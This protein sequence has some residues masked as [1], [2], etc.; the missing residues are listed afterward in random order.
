MFINSS[1]KATTLVIIIGLITLYSSSLTFARQIPRD[2][3]LTDNEAEIRLGFN[4]NE[5]ERF[6]R[7]DVEYEQ[8]LKEH[9]S[10]EHSDDRFY[11]CDQCDKVLERKM[12][13]SNHIRIH[14]SNINK[15]CE[16]C[17]QYFKI[18]SIHNHVKIMIK[19]FQLT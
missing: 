7:P 16:N 5:F 14:S 19:V 12:K 8:E 4:G 10:R 18:G 6:R 15:K 1:P 17:G 13:L 9:I 11:K 2:R 3:V